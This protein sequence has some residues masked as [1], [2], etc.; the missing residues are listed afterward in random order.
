MGLN[1]VLNVKVLAGAFKQEN[2]LGGVFS[3]IAKYL[4]KLVASSTAVPPAGAWL[5]SW[6]SAGAGAGAGPGAD[7]A[8]PRS[9]R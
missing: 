4:R 5:D 7:S 9:Q 6:S 2:A 8:E 1:S 3:V